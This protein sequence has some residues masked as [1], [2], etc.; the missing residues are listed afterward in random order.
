MNMKREKR[1]GEG[2]RGRWRRW[3]RGEEV[4]E[5]QNSNMTELKAERESYL[6]RQQLDVGLTK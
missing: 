6:K 2:E 1:G 4:E 3:S 5:E